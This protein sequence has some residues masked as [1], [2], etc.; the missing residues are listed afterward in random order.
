MKLPFKH[1]RFDK[2]LVSKIQPL[3]K[4]DNWHGL[5][6][7]MEDWAVIAIA[8]ALSVW[9]WQ[10]L[11]L[12]AASSVYFLSV[13]AIGAKQRG[14]KV[15]NHMGTHKAIAKNPYLNY[16]I[17]T[18]FA[19]WL[20][21]ESFSGYDDTH[22]SLEN[23]HHPNLGTEKDVDYMAIVAL[24]LYGEGCHA[25]N[26]RKFLWLL[27][28]KSFGYMTLLL[29]NCLVNPQEK[30]TERAIRLSY[31]ISLL[32]ILIWAGLGLPI[33]VYWFVPL[34]TSAIWLG[35]IIQLTQHYPLLDS[36]QHETYDIHLSR[37]RILD[38]LSNFLIGSHCEGYHL[39]HHLYPK[40]PLWRMKAAHRILMA[41][42]IYASLHQETGMT[43][44]VKSIIPES[45]FEKRVIPSKRV[46]W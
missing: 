16:L 32:A 21:L 7:L 27:P 13:I 44:L 1:Y 38:P 17:S 42:P 37:N 9:A 20:V 36:Q 12:F 8:I 25:E 10:H 28:L 4:L 14:L 3:H 22:N 43:S 18:V 6:M 34:F 23:G 30:S 33:L 15:I 5:L 40:L 35:M 11:S 45:L 29:K 41:S 26:I 24:G 19:A 2:R 39:I 46:K 31:L